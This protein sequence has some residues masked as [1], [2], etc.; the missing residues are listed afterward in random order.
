MQRNN[1]KGRV[2]M[3]SITETTVRRNAHSPGLSPTVAIITKK[4]ENNSLNCS[5]TFGVK[6]SCFINIRL[7]YFKC[8]GKEKFKKSIRKA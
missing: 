3:I 8:K 1:E 6:N 4:R 2:T 5:L 7:K